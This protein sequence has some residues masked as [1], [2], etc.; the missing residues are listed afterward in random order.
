MYVMLKV[1]IGDVHEEEC[2]HE[3]N[4][5]ANSRTIK[6][7]ASSADSYD[8]DK[9]SKTGA[10]MVWMEAKVIRSLAIMT[11]LVASDS[12]GDVGRRTNAVNSVR[13]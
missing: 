12:S 4:H 13:R 2:T 10:I 11:A 9:S 8:I 3:Y 5:T 1:R 6:N 7:D